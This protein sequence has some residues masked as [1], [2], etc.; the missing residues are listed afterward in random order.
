[1][2]AK[3]MSSRGSS[4]RCTAAVGMSRPGDPPGIPKGRPRNI[5]VAAPKDPT[6]DD[7]SSVSSIYPAGPDNEQPGD[8]PAGEPAKCWPWQ[9]P[10]WHEDSTREWN[11]GWWQPA[12][13]RSRKDEPQCDPILQLMDTWD[14]QDAKR[15]YDTAARAVQTAEL[16]WQRG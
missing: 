3:L 16:R 10:W 8:E 9:R 13:K 15:R 14:K 6:T 2:H 5:A 12:A 1:M 11:C 7:E 4:C